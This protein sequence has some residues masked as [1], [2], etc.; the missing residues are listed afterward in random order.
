MDSNQRNAHPV[1]RSVKRRSVSVY[2]LKFVLALLLIIGFGG[3]LI[4]GLVGVQKAAW[5]QPGTDVADQSAPVEGENALYICPMMCTPPQEE[6]GRCPVCAM[7]LVPSTM[8]PNENDGVS[9]WIEPA[10]RR[11]ARI[12]TVKVEAAPRSRRIRAV[13]ELHYN[14]GTMKTL[15]AYVDGR[16]EELYANYTGVIVEEGDRLALQYSPAIYSSQIDYLTAIQ[17]RNASS[18]LSGNDLFSDRLMAGAKNRL[19][20]FGMTEDQIAELEEADKA[21][22]RM[23]LCA[24]IS[25]TVIEKAAEEGQYVTTGQAIYRLADLSTVWLMLHLFPE[26]AAAVRYGWKVEAKVQ[27]MPGRTFTGR[28]AFID[29]MVDPETRTVRVRVVLP[30]EEGL[31]RVGDYVKATIDVPLAGDGGPASLVYDPEL[32]DMWISPRHPDV[33]ESSEGAC[34]ICGVPLEPVSEFGFAEEPIQGNDVLILPRDAVLS[35]GENSV[36]YVETEPGR[37]EL[38]KLV[39]GPNLGDEVVVIEGVEEGEDVA[40]SGNFLID[41]QMQLAGNPS[42]IDPDKRS[43]EPT[44]EEIEAITIRETLATL[45]PEDRALAEAQRICPVTKAMLGSMGAPPKI[46]VD[47]RTVFLCCIGCEAEVRATPDYYFRVLEQAN[48]AATEEENEASGDE[49]LPDS[50]SGLSPED[51]ALVQRQS[52]CPV[53]EMSLG[54]M[55]EPIKV[56]VDGTPVFIC[57]EGCRSKLLAD[58]ETYLSILNQE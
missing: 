35:V 43:S 29:P 6:P 44:A 13:G 34:R 5:F 49:P 10:A 22:S 40:R 30:N 17:S 25:G 33:I 4:A 53:T 51:L 46:E 2:I 19:I 58:P 38:R 56:D 27:S 42:L 52:I 45:S 12:Q 7:E 9:V 48:E 24:P 37:F 32:V 3:A 31:L 8:G 20:E 1:L 36:A 54:S 47:G 11:V 39:L 18:G 26:D 57:C 41:S 15:A 23:Y 50:L 16:I 14:E 55:G 28:V 21:S